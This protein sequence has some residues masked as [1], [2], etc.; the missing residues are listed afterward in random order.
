MTDF[1]P[2][3]QAMLDVLADGLPHTREELHACLPDELGNPRNVHHHLYPLRKQLRLMG[4]DI[5]CEWVNHRP[6]Y[7]HV[8]LLPAARSS[9]SA[10]TP[11]Q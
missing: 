3:Q 7:R 1:T 11:R 5:L 8:I 6:R 9:I 2:T 10:P 4:Q